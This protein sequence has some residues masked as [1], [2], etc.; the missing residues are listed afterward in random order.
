MPAG[1]R[2]CVCVCVAACGGS[3]RQ[4]SALFKAADD[5]I[6]FHVDE[7]SHDRHIWQLYE[8][9]RASP[10]GH[11]RVTV[12]GVEYSLT[13]SMLDTLPSAK[14]LTKEAQALLATSFGGTDKLVA[15][16]LGTLKREKIRELSTTVATLLRDYPPPP[17]PPAAE[18]GG[19]AKPHA[20]V[21]RIA[22][23]WSEVPGAHLLGE[24]ALI[25][26]DT[27][28][29]SGV[30]GGG[31]ACVAPAMLTAEGGE[32]RLHEPYPLFPFSLPVTLLKFRREGL[33]DKAVSTVC[34]S[35]LL[36]QCH[37]ATRTRCATASFRA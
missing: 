14:G 29:A 7:L 9:A 12:E 8:Q 11:V 19:G 2:A 5:N 34:R 35:G 6:K 22:L 37:M 3:L 15:G 36:T 13:H 20:G 17:P 28:L 32:A 26:D 31:G 24:R 10:H 1:A 25:V 27:P 18:G 4:V 33:T 21:A 16:V 30:D 23:S